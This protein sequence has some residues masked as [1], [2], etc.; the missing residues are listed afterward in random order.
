MVVA[1]HE[2]TKHNYRRSAA[3]LGYLDWATQ[4]DPF[5]RYDG[6]PLVVLPLPGEGRDL[7]FWKLYFQP[8]G[9]PAPLTLEASV[10]TREETD[11]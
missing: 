5:R 11:P 9:N 2:R 4:L 7:P 10:H 6:A 3:S 1:Y 8:H